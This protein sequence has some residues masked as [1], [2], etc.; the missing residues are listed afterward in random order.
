MLQARTSIDQLRRLGAALGLAP[1]ERAKL[2]STRPAG[3]EDEVE[4]LFREAGYP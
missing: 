3:Q 4:R 2:P 1:V